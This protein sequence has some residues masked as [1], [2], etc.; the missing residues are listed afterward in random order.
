MF[1]IMQGLVDASYLKEVI[2]ERSAAKTSCLI[3]HCI[4]GRVC[5]DLRTSYR[6]PEPIFYAV[7]PLL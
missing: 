2:I 3:Q 4:A 7:P 6:M 1:A 5:P